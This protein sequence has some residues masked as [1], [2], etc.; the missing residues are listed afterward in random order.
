MSNITGA[1]VVLHTIY[2]TKPCVILVFDYNKLWGEPGGRLQKSYSIEM[3]AK[4][5][6]LEETCLAIDIRRKTLAKYLNVIGNKSGSQYRAYFY[7]TKPISIETYYK[8]RESLQKR[9]VD[10]KYLETTGLTYVEISNLNKSKIYDVF[11]K[12]IRI[13]PR[14][15][16]VLKND[17]LKYLECYYSGYYS[18]Y[19]LIKFT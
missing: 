7:Q 6:V 17:G 11:G 10:P 15:K 1:G 14:F 2:K 5:E 12:R 3:S 19:G 9:K 4:N 18:R 16:F 13:T 8:N